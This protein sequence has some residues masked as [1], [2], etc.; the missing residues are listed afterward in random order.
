M[1]SIFDAF[2]AGHA[3]L[4][5]D[6]SLLIQ[7]APSRYVAWGL[8]FLIV[9]GLSFLL[10]RKNIC[11]PCGVVFFFASFVIP[12]IFLPSFAIDSVRFNPTGLSV[13]TGFWLKPT[14]HDYSLEGLT[15]ILERSKPGKRRG[16]ESLFW[17]F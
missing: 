8:T 9:A 2:S 5:P 17:V 1:G 16:Q 10:W 15:A 3:A 13:R 4:Q 14:H 12:L 11:K 6:G 7:S